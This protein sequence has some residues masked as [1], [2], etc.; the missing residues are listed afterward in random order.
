MS[1]TSPLGYVHLAVC[2]NLVR[3][4]FWFAQVP[5]SLW[6]HP[7]VLPAAM[8]TVCCYGNSQL[9]LSNSGLL[10][11]QD[12]TSHVHDIQEILNRARQKYFS[13]VM[14]VITMCKHQIPH[15]HRNIAHD[16]SVNN[17]RLEWNIPPLIQLN[18]IWCILW[19]SPCIFSM[20][21]GCPSAD[22]P[23]PPQVSYRTSLAGYH[24]LVNSSSHCAGKAIPLLV[25]TQNPMK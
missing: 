1:I 11:Q 21:S 10:E 20:S 7:W 19:E 5:C 23:L 24:L 6:Q 18:H 2:D 16:S 14:W 15:S 22:I 25:S 17:I 13:R 8:V 4:N 3:F 12:Q 9:D